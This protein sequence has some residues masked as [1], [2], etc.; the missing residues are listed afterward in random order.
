LDNI[1]N[2]DFTSDGTGHAI[3]LTSAH[4]GSSYTIV[5]C[6]YT[7]YASIDGSTGDEVIYNNSGGAVTIT[8][9]GGDTPTV[10]NGTSASTTIVSGAVTVQVTAKTAAGANVENA[11]VL[12]KA[13]DDTGPFPFDETVTIVNSGT[14]ATVTHTGH[15]MLNL[16][17]ISIEGASLGA[18]NGVFTTTWISVNSYSYTMSS[19]P[20]SSP[21]GTIK[22]TFVALSGLTNGSGVISTSRV[23][24][25]DQPVVGWAR[26]SSATPYYK[27]APIVGDVDSVDGFN[28]TGILISDE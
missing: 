12:V 7:G 15:G 3:E 23:Y 24:T 2:C 25:S 13:S 20:G 28:A 26:K 14:T 1:D 9:S 27:S 8:I 18:N 21:T 22:A 19:A 4:A 11:R 16:D 17:K 10:M 5:G 6:T